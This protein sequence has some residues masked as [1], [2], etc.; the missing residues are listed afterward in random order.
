MNKFDTT[1]Q[2]SQYLT[3]SG[4]TEDSTGGGFSAWFLQF[5]VP[6]GRWQVMLTDWETDTACLRP[7]KPIGIA[8]YGPGGEGTEELFEVL[9]EP[10]KLPETIA[11]FTKEGEARFGAGTKVQ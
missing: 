10:T 2:I 4:F 5:D 8:L 3:D 9:P 11:R 6:A 1:E 7:E